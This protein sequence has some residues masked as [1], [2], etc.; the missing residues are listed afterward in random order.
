MELDVHLTQDSRVAVIHD[1]TLDRTTNGSGPV[2]EHT[3][4]ELQALDAG[5]WFEK[6]YKGERIPSLDQV[7]DRYAGRLHVHIE[8]KSETEGLP[9]RC[10]ELVRAREMTE[11]VTMTSFHVPHLEVL[12]SFA[13]ELRLAL[14]TVELNEGVLR[15]ALDLGAMAMSHHSASVTPDW[16]ERLHRAGLSVHVWGVS[17]EA[18]MRR[19]VELDVDG[20]TID[21]PDKL[22]AYLKKLTA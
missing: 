15:I 9:E 11:G 19:L 10:A 3:L 2:A 4:A 6:R 1:D 16:V 14:L 12:R 18:D 21:Y 20:L 22:E 8:I 13:P 5:S 17:G 7:L